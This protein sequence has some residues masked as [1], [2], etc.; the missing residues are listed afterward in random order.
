MTSAS[1]GAPTVCPVD[2]EAAL[3]ALPKVMGDDLELLVVEHLDGALARRDDGVMSIVV[4]RSKRSV[5]SA[6][7]CALKRS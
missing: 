2:G 3:Q 1:P 4:S 7:L 5:S 6:R